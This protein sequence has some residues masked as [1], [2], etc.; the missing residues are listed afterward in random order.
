MRKKRNDFD[1]L[2]GCRHLENLSP[3]A[4]CSTFTTLMLKALNQNVV[5]DAGRYLRSLHTEGLCTLKV[6][7]TVSPKCLYAF[8]CI[9]NLTNQSR[10]E[11]SNSDA[12]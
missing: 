4:M 3:S 12:Y 2:Q 5:E 10:T 7:A 9:H 11:T 6:S 1:M 8:F